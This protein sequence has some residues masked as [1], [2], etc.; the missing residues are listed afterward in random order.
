MFYF[1]DMALHLKKLIKSHASDSKLGEVKAYDKLIKT[2]R[3]PCL[4]EKK[5]PIRN[6]LLFNVVA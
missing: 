5:N 1:K 2:Y 6:D 4:A 3:V